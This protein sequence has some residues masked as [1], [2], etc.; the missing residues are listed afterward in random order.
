[1]KI[2]IPLI[3]SNGDIVGFFGDGDD[4]GDDDGFINNNP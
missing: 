2:L 3:Q 4:F 1:L